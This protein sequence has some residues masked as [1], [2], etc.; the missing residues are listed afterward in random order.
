MLIWKTHKY[1]ILL[2]TALAYFL[3]Y[4]AALVMHIIRCILVSAA[5]CLGIAFYY[6][7]KL[8]LLIIG[9]L[10]IQV[11]GSYLTAHV[12][13]ESVEEDQD[14]EQIAGENIVDGSCCNFGLTN[15]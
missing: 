6:S 8:S 4:Y 3:I 15:Q 9:F 7:W 11:L 13:T 1:L 2:P 10:P 5:F 14:D 12:L